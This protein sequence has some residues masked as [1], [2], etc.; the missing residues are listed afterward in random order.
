M[1]STKVGTGQVGLILSRQFAFRIRWHPPLLAELAA[2]NF[3]GGG[4]GSINID[5]TRRILPADLTIPQLSDHHC[6][7]RRSI[8]FPISDLCETQILPSP[9]PQK[10]V[11]STFMRPLLNPAN[12]P[13]HNPLLP[14]RR[15][16]LAAPEHHRKPRG[17]RPDFFSRSSKSKSLFRGSLKIRRGLIIFERKFNCGILR[18]MTI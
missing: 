14:G 3:F 6:L 7:F 17:D 11:T 18:Y 4:G 5:T 10:P 2:T 1:A 16:G 13:I 15:H 12:P 8:F 9:P